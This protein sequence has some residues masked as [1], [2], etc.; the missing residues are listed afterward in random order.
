M[1]QANAKRQR[2]KVPMSIKIMPNDGMNII[3]NFGPTGWV[4]E[5]HYE[6]WKNRRVLGYAKSTR[7]V[8][9]W[10]WHAERWSRR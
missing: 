7:M 5:S 1:P 2:G 10:H 3:D 8:G 6:L 9:I 4:F